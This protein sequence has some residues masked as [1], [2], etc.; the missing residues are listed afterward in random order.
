MSITPKL[1]EALLNWSQVFM[2]RSM[3]E[4]TQWMANKDLSRSQTG[5]LMHIHF[6]GKCP[7]T[8]IGIHLNIS[9]PAASTLVDRL[10][11]IGL[12][13]RIDDPLDRRVKLVDLS[14]E[15]KSLLNEGFQARVNWMQ[16]LGDFLP[17]QEQDHI[18]SA[19]TTLMDAAT[20]ASEHRGHKHS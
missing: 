12:V 4:S 13:K 17:D 18:A 15:G 19:L 1:K 11:H 6:H 5:A 14:K 2:R 10:V 3:Q 8:A 7:I 20:K 9:T 16:E